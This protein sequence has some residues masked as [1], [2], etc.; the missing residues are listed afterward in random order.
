MRPG[1]QVGPGCTPGY[2]TRSCVPPFHRAITPLPAPQILVPEVLALRPGALLPCPPLP[3]LLSLTPPLQCLV[4]RPLATIPPQIPIPKVLALLPGA[5]S[6]G[7][8][9]ASSFPGP[10]S[11]LA[12]VS[13]EHYVRLVAALSSVAV[14]AGRSLAVPRTSCD[15]PW[16]SGWCIL[17]IV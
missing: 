12:L 10:S 4:P 7:P 9:P 1:Q 3:L 5:L 15:H 2:H 11:P 8:A 17:M 13:K 6:P 16:V 14:V